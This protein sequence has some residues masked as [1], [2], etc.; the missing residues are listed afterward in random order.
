MI[1]KIAPVLLFGTMLLLL[2]GCTTISP[3]AV[4]Q[5]PTQAA[6][7]VVS[8]QTPVVQ[9]V[10]VVVT[11]T[12]D[13]VDSP[14]ALPPTDIPVPTATATSAPT[15]VYPTATPGAYDTNGTP[16]AS[17]SSITITNIQENSSGKALITWTSSGT[18]PKGFM[19]FYSESYANPY[20]GGYPYY[21]ITDGSVHSAYVDGTPGKT[22]SYRICQ[23]SGSG[24]IF[25][26]N[27]YSFTYP[28][29]T[30]TP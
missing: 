23:S 1:K 3:T 21:T 24:C 30:S 7:E 16:V 4:V 27:S 20:Y 15:V 8:T 13:V 2:A 12:P 10:I 5:P 6:T 28:A 14:T 9:T 22:Y 25:Y 26:S 17:S 29:A 19:I 18:F 11:A